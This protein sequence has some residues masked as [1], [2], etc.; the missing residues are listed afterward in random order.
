V[1]EWIGAEIV[2]VD[3][4]QVYRDMDLGTAKPVAEERER[5][6]HHLIDIADPETVFTVAEF[7]AAGR[8]VLADLERRAVPA[9]IAG[10]SGLHFRS[11]VDPLEFPPSNSEVRAEIEALDPEAAVQALIREDPEAGAIVDL[12]NP[13]RVTRALEIFRLTG[14]TPSERAASEEAEAVRSYQPL[15][16]LTV[17]GFDPGERLRERVRRRFGLMLLAGLLE[18]VRVLAPRLGPTAAKAV[19]YRELLGVLRGEMALDEAID[20]V[21]D[22]SCA[23]AGRQRTFFRRDPRVRWLEWDDDA[24]ARV[25]VAKKALQEA[26][27]TS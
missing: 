27:W 21:V 9:L 12:Q 13:R 7:Q 16:P 1:A 25:A 8:S 23:L 11:L 3:S 14:R 15:F 18:E 22:A 20:A 26:G 5:V 6:R 19:G 10:G 17:L 24:D 2:S 4:M